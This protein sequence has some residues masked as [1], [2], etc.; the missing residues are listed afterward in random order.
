VPVIAWLLV[1]LAA[2]TA[3]LTIAKS[4]IFSPVRDWIGERND[5]FYELVSC[6]YC[7]SHWFGLIGLLAP[8]VPIASWWQYP[9]VWLASTGLAAL[10]GSVVKKLLT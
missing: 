6:H 9:V 8:P 4:Y 1:C 10:Y 2:G 3:A 7:L 5:W